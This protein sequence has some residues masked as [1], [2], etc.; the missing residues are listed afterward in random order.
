MTFERSVRSHLVKEQE[1]GILSTGR[2]MVRGME[3]SIRLA[4]FGN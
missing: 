3:T 4:C 1:K 2:N